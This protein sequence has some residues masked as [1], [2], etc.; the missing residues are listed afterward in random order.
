VRNFGIFGR[1]RDVLNLG[2]FL[3]ALYGTS[4]MI[5][6]PVLKQL[7]EGHDSDS[8]EDSVVFDMG[9]TKLYLRPNHTE[10]TLCALFVHSQVSRGTADALSLYLSHFTKKSDRPRFW[11]S[12]HANMSYML[13]SM[14]HP[15]VCAALDVR[16]GCQQSWLL[17]V[18]EEDLKVS[19]L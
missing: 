9:S 14:A 8:E 6:Q 7:P 19:I 17:V 12:I 1:T 11:R 2:A 10:R 13:Q 5:R 15:L 4:S 3:F 18:R 16:L